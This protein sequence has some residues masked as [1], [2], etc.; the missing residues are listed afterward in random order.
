[1]QREWIGAETTPATPHALGFEWIQLDWNDAADLDWLRL[2]SGLDA[3]TVA[4]LIE[5]YTRARVFLT[6][7]RQWVATLR[8]LIPEPGDDQLVSIRLIASASRIITITKSRLPVLQAIQRRFQRRQGRG[9]SSTRFLILLCE[10]VEGQFTDY[11]VEL[12]ERADALE[13]TLEESNRLRGSQLRAMR[14]AVSRLRRHLLPQRDAVQQLGRLAVEA[15]LDN[16][17]AHKRRHAGRW[18][19]IQNAFARSVEIHHELEQRLQIIQDSVRTQAEQQINRTMYLLTLATTFFMPLTF[20]TSLLG[21]NVAGIPGADS[22]YA[23][24]GLCGAFAAMG[25]C[26]WWLFRRWRLVNR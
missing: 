15:P 19:E 4:S 13:E 14:L 11:L 16:G 20:V 1:M 18:R 22:R 23:F 9:R 7:D 21:M 3:V 12:E 25:A 8:A 6:D 26:Q 2:E 24:F 5:E 10:L 17:R